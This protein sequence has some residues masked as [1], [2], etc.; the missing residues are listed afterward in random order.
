[1]MILKLVLRVFWKKTSTEGIE[2]LCFGDFNCDMLPRKLSAD[3]RDLRQLFNLYQIT[4]LIKSPT[5]IASNSSTLIDLALATD[6]EKIVASGVLQY[7]ISD[8]SLI[9]IV[10]RARKTRNTFKNIQFRNLKN[11]SAKDSLQIY[12]IFHG[13]RLTYR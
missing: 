10:R 3:V 4:Q 5:R 11:Y 13:R 12:I 2:L 6:V 9:Y 8:H 7:S 1:M